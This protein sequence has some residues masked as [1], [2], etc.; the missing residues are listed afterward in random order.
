MDRRPLKNG[1]DGRFARCHVYANGIVV[2]ATMRRVHHRPFPGHTVEHL[3]E[4]GRNAEVVVVVLP[5][6]QRSAGAEEH[7][8]RSEA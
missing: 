7:F 1:R 5:D 2:G 8:D 4:H 6:A 3:L